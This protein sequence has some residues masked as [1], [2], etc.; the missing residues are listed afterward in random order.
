[1]P[2]RGRGGP[3]VADKPIPRTPQKRC[4]CGELI[5]SPKKKLCWDCE[6]KNVEA[7]KKLRV[8]RK[9]S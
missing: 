9:A 4:G 1:M 2:S 3:G 5:A 7:R 8:K 6:G